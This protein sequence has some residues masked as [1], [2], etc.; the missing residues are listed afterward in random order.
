MNV[1]DDGVAYQ[2]LEQ[3]HQ[4]NAFTVTGGTPTQ[5]GSTSIATVDAGCLRITK[6][7]TTITFYR[8]GDCSSW[9]QDE[10][11]TFTVPANIYP[12][13]DFSTGGSQSSGSAGTDFDSFNVA[14]GTVDSAGY[15]AAGNWTSAS[16]TYTSD[17]VQKIMVNY[18][19]SAAGSPAI[20]YV[21]IVK[22]SDGTVLYVD[23]TDIVAG[24]THS[25]TVPSSDLLKVNWKVVIGLK[26]SGVGTP[27]ITNVDVT[28]GAPPAPPNPIT[29][30]IGLATSAVAAL[31]VVMGVII[32]FICIYLVLFSV[33]DRFLDPS[34][35]KRGKS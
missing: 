20:D 6:S 34:V 16:Q 17:I 18:T 3:F 26:G 5:V 30:T 8:A 2:Y 35:Y 23:N 13:I 12:I 7:A 14:S 11:T 32:A 9:I 29:E 24:T 19:L 1:A 25:Y 28:A 33:K 22:A 10:Q 27:T 21:K 4:F 31:L 15:R